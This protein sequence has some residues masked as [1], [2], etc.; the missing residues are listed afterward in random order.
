MVIWDKGRSESDQNNCLVL[1]E[2]PLEFLRH[3][4]LDKGRTEFRAET[5]CR[6]ELHLLIK[7]L[8]PVFEAIWAK[9]IG[10]VSDSDEVIDVERPKVLVEGVSGERLLPS[11]GPEDVLA[12]VL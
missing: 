4:F 5:S 8:S 3:L 11:K 10:H 6:I 7:S 9:A 2:E 12:E 1:L